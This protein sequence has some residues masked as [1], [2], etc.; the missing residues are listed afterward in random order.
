MVVNADAVQCYIG[1]RS[2]EGMR[3]L[4]SC[5]ATCK[6]SRQNSGWLVSQHQQESLLSC[7]IH[8]PTMH[9][10]LLLRKTHHHDCGRWPGMSGTE[11]M[12]SAT[13]C[14]G[15]RDEPNDHIVGMFCAA[16]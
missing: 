14:G 9:V 11:R 6:S 5:N 10:R 2:Q 12:N 4:C 16:L 8:E 13:H 7:G 3:H 1:G 15:G